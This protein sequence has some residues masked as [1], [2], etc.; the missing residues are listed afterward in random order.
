MAESRRSDGETP[1]DLVF[2]DVRIGEASLDGQ[3]VLVPASA[4]DLVVRVAGPHVPPLVPRHH[5]NR[6]DVRA[7]AFDTSMLTSVSNRSRRT[8]CTRERSS[9]EVD[10]KGR[11]MQGSSFVAVCLVR[12]DGSGRG[13]VQVGSLCKRLTSSWLAPRGKCWRLSVRRMGG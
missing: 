7:G 10:T 3:D 9:T 8:A 2:G 4:K 13:S 5:E 1:A 12:G 11:P 6:V